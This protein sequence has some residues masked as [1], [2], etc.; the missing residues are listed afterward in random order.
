V[1]VI[2]LQKMQMQ[3]DPGELVS[4]EPRGT[5]YPT[6]K[7]ID[8]W[9]T[10]TVSHGALMEADFSKVTVPASAETKAGSAKGDGWLLELNPGWQLKDGA[11][12]GDWTIAKASP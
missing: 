1:L 11:R 9:G 3:F 12:P 8:T 4:L 7:I 10:L 5:V 6:I 2:S